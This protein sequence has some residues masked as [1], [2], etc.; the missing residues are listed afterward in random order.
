MTSKYSEIF[1]AQYANRGMHK[2][3]LECEG[4]AD[5]FFRK[6]QEPVSAVAGLLTSW[7]VKTRH[8][9]GKMLLQIQSFQLQCRGDQC[10][11]YRP[12]FGR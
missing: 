3:V 1:Y 2:G 10:T 8:I 4:K 11:F 6:V 7:C 9:F 5:P 12:G